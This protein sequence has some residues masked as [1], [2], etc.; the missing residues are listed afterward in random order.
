MLEEN[1]LRAERLILTP[2]FEGVDSQWLRRHDETETLRKEIERMAELS[3][4]F[5]L[6]ESGTSSL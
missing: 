1:S 6:I 4:F 5:F 3:S 2:G